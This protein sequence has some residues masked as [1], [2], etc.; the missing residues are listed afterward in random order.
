MKLP[1][2]LSQT[3][4]ATATLALASTTL[5]ASEFST[6]DLKKM[7]VFVSNFTELN[8]LNLESKEFLKSPEDYI[9]FGIW[10]HY[11]NNYKLITR[12]FEKCSGEGKVPDFCK[13]GTLAIDGK[14]V[15]AA[16]EHYF[17]QKITDFKSID[18]FHYD[19]KTFYFEGADGE[20]RP[21]AHITEAWTQEDGTVFMKGYALTEFGDDTT[22]KRN[23][24]VKAKP[25]TWK[26]KN[27][28]CMLSIEEQISAQ[29]N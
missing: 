16:I 14:Q 18:H 17:G 12:N 26:N 2:F 19:G 24:Q 3:I 1:K 8:L 10:H 11:I 9:P 7:S 5:A 28:W 21:T 25:C 15:T 13:Y 27:T 29:Q 20:A 6:K 22:E 4:L 23:I